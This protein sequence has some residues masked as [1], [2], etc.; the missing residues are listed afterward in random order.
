MPTT[1]P[2]AESLSVT[3]VR[4]SSAARW[5][6]AVWLGR[7]GLS[8]NR[9]RHT[10]NGPLPTYGEMPL[11]LITACH[12]A[13]TTTTVSTAFSNE[14]AT[15][16]TRSP[17]RRPRVRPGAP[18]APPP[19]SRSWQPRRTAGRPPRPAPSRGCLAG[20]SA[21]MPTLRS[22]AP[23]YSPRTAPRNDDGTAICRALRIAGTAATRRTLCQLGPPPAAVHPDDV[24]AGPVGR[25]ETE[26]GTDHRGEEDAQ[27]GEEDRGRRRVTRTR[28][29]AEHHDGDATH[30]H[31]GKAVADDR[32][33]DHD[34]L[35]LREQ[36]HQGE[37]AA[38]RCR[39]PTRT[40]SSPR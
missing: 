29:A 33:L 35:D 14:R 20:G 15:L 16:L 1:K 40:R 13:S 5:S 17:S 25:L 36:Q 38:G 39:C 11:K 18:P 9:N 6:A 2:S 26:Q 4:G 32:D 30:R 8:T 19:R 7:S 10:S 23:M 28:G 3:P 24:E 37:R 31:H 21:G 12:S 22:V 34:R 27:G